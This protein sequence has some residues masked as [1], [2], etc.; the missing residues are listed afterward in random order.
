MKKVLFI[1]QNLAR[2]GS[3]M[4]LWYL[5]KYLDSSKYSVYVFCLSKG[6]LFN[7]LPN[8]IEKSILY[9]NSG[10]RYLKVYRAI[11]KV[12]GVNVVDYQ[13][14]QIQKRFKSDLWYVNTIVIPQVYDI[15]KK[16]NVKVVTHFHELLYAYTFIRYTDLKKIVENSD[17][18]I[19]CSNE[20]GNRAIEMG[21]QN[22]KIQHNFID[23]NTINIDV[24]RVAEIKTALG[25]QPDDFVWVISGGA[26]YMKGL[27]YIIP[28]LESF[29]EKP[30][31]ILW[32]GKL[33]ND[34]LEFY[35]R[36][37]ADKKYPQK[38]F[39]PGALS[40]DY[41]NYMA[42][43]NGCLL[44]SREESFSLVML[45][46]AFI[47]LPVVAFDIGIAKDFIKEGMGHVA[48]SRNLDEIIRLMEEVHQTHTGINKDI[49]RQ[50]A[51]QYDVTKQLANYGKLL[52]DIF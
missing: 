22:V 25:I 26:T 35:V 15:A 40:S 13:L 9:K 37:V 3:E 16:L 36:T 27:D 30:V 48:K 51:I 19:A 34:G 7:M 5:L 33:L 50:E 42:V 46:A 10:K 45:E 20:T 12:F 32:L 8:H 47:G 38:L 44:L 49:L 17:T 24:K 52:D 29:K 31:K 23:F 2:T 14:N 4:I 39:F 11:L 41:Y 6:E 1:T 28:I 18:C 43:A 21:A